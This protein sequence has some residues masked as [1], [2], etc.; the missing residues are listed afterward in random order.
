MY[1]SIICRYHEIATK[2]NNR[3]MFERCLVENIRHLLDGR[4]PCRV[5]RVR[6]RV[7]VE[8]KHE[9]DFT[10]E[11]LETIKPR[12]AKVFGLESVSPAARVA[13]A[14]G[15]RARHRRGA[16]RR[17]CARSRESPMNRRTSRRPRCDPPRTASVPDAPSRSSGARPPSRSCTPCQPSTLRS[18]ALQHDSIRFDEHYGTRPASSSIR[19]REQFRT[20]WRKETWAPTGR[21]SPM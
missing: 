17:V 10:G 2:G 13:V 19:R 3:N 9:G 7:W 12:L 8:P 18:C 21:L 11:E 20:D 5:H 16:D 14:E 6:G 1:N 4:A 15:R